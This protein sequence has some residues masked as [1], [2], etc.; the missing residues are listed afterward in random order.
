MK[1]KTRISSFE[2]FFVLL[3]TQVGV[4]LLSLPFE[5]YKGVKHDGWISILIS[6]F[7][8]QM[9]IFLIWSLCRRFPHNTLF[10]FSTIIVGKFLGSVMNLGYII[11]FLIVVSYV[12][13]VFTDILKRWILTETPPWIFFLVGFCILV[14]GCWGTVKNMVS[15]FSFIS[16]FILGMLFISF[17]VFLEP[18]IDIRYL[19]PIGSEGIG[20]IIKSTKDSFVSFLGFE[21][22]LIYFAFLKKPHKASAIKGAISATLFITF[23]YVYIVIIATIMFSPDEILLVPEP[24]LYMLKAISLP[25]LERLDLFF[26]SIWIIVVASTVISYSYLASMGINKL[27][28]LRHKKSVFIAGAFVFCLV[29]LLYGRIELRQLGNLVTSVSYF[30][31]VIFPGILLV[32]S[33][34]FKKRGAYYEEK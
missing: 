32:I 14:Y 11:Y 13:M 5:T 7:L 28:H 15:L 2:L 31:S 26:L 12:F 1:V 22:L 30:F 6:G 8:V 34:V 18:G 33:F 19:F 21:T 25:I 23:F 9:T 3:Q 4:G 17:F 20:V 10:D 27:F 16:I 29:F 24:V